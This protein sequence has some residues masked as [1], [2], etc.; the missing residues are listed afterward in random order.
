MQFY[1]RFVFVC[2][3]IGLTTLLMLICGC[4]ATP[5]KAAAVSKQGQQQVFTLAEKAERSGFYQLAIDMHKSQL[6]KYGN[7]DSPV[8]GEH[9]TALFWLYRK[10]QQFTHAMA[11]LSDTERHVS[12]SQVL[13]DQQHQMT[14]SRRYNGLMNWRCIRAVSLL[15]SLD[16]NQTNTNSASAEQAW[17]WLSTSPTLDYRS[18]QPELRHCYSLQAHL[19][20]LRGQLDQAQELYQ[21]LLLSDP[22]HWPY[23]YNLALIYLLEKHTNKAQALLLPDCQQS[24]CPLPL[25]QLLALSYGLQNNEQQALKWLSPLAPDEQQQQLNVYRQFRERLNTDVGSL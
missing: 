12:L 16:S 23:R 24:T 5:E 17:L 13:S 21:R 8:S 10:S 11:L 18:L 1:C 25:M 7:T 6:D 3:C 2:R 20:A 22:E 19:F 4:S 15:D 9:R 14:I